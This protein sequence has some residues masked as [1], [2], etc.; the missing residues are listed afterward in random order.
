[1]AKHCTVAYVIFDL[2]MYAA[3]NKEDRVL[4]RWIK[5]AQAF[6]IPNGLLKLIQGLWLLDHKDFDVSP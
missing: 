6:N 3:D 1:M 4:D 5:Y 2:L